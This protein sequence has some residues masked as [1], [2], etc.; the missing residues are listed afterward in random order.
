M[1]ILNIGKK[2]SFHTV[3]ACTFVKVQVGKTKF[4]LMQI[5]CYQVTDSLSCAQYLIEET[6]K[7]KTFI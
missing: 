7:N 6:H 5:Y 2:Y 3:S 4:P 1:N